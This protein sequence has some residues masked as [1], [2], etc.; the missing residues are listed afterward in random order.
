MRKPSR[1]FFQNWITGPSHMLPSLPIKFR[2][3]MT[4]RFPN[5]QDWAT[6]HLTFAGKRG[7]ADPDLE[8]NTPSLAKTKIAALAKTLTLVGLA[9]ITLFVLR[10]FFDLLNLISIV[11]LIPVLVAA[12][13]WGTLPAVVAALAGAAGA[14]FF[15][16]PPYFSF[17]V[18]D[19]QNVADLVVFLTV[20]LVAGDMAARL[21]RETIN[22]HR[23]ERE[24]RELYVFSR[25]LAA[26]FTLEDL[27]AATQDYLSMTLGLHVFLFEG[28]EIGRR[29]SDIAVIPQPV[30]Q[31]AAAII[32]SGELQTRMHG[33]WLIRSVSL[34]TTR[35]VVIVDMGEGAGDVQ[36]AVR[37]RV[38]TVLEEATI[39]LARLDVARALEE[40][41]VQSRVDALS[42]ALIGAVSHDLRTPLASIL[43]SVSVLGQMAVISGDPRVQSLVS[44]VHDQAT[45][46]DHDLKQLLDTARISARGD[47]LHHEWTDPVDIVNA[48]IEHK[49]TQIAGHHLELSLAPDLPL[50]K[51]HSALVEQALGQLLENAAKYSPIGS[52]IK[53]SA[54][55]ERHNL[56]LSVCDEGRGLTPDEKRKIGER[57]FRGGPPLA[58]VPGSGLGLWIAHTFIAANGGR[59]DAESSGPGLG[60]TV[61]IRLPVARDE[62]SDTAKILTRR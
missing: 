6:T 56:V 33:A 28:N 58:V 55:A 46:L 2:Q 52:T 4:V 30:R 19:T 1:I 32:A 22:L 11:Y 10:G 15:F 25:Q 26:C 57:S 14:D 38:D 60:T 37:R 54:I 7:A 40:A 47:Q 20:A 9:T 13:R 42:D 24:I 29:L 16:Y 45:Q 49:R 31:E 34:G 48:A 36:S 5:I 39:T 51:V 59:L 12:V 53:V 50:I 3:S 27:T 21:K 61:S 44:G 62:S 41:K 35:Y 43:G 8:A 18:A 23:R 17:W